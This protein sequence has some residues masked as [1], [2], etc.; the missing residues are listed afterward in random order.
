VNKPVLDKS[1]LTIYITFISSLKD[2]GNYAINKYQS[3]SNE[4]KAVD[5]EKQMMHYYT[6]AQ[7]ALEIA[8]NQDNRNSI[9]NEN[10][11]QAQN[12]RDQVL[13]LRSPGT[14]NENNPQLDAVIT[15]LEKTF[16]ALTSGNAS[17]SFS[18][19]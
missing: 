1:V 19:M 13:N 5:M 8:G 15:I 14:S 12:M 6:R 4:V 18:P 16:G 9:Y 7:N 11:M 2:L 10:V 3:I 17:S